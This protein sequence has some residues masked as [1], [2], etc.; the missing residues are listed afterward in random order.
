MEVGRAVLNLKARRGN[1][2]MRKRYLHVLLIMAMLLTVLLSSMTVFGADKYKYKTINTKAKKWV[3]VKQGLQTYS[4][5]SGKWTYT[6]NMYKI[7]VS[8]PG[9][10]TIKWKTKEEY[11]SLR[12]YKQKKD[13]KDGDS[14]A[15]IERNHSAKIAVDKGVYY[16]SAGGSSSQPGKIGKFQYTFKKVKPTANY[17]PGTAKYLTPGKTATICMTPEY[18]YSRWYRITLPKKKSITFWCTKWSGGSKSDDPGYYVTVY[19]S[20][21]KYIDM[22]HAGSGSSQYFSSDYQEAGTY[23]IRVKSPSY[24][25]D[26]LYGFLTTLKWK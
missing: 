3:N 2:K 25:Y 4:E 20:D 12:L 8:S 11:T 5:K 22:E 7:K 16:A 17:S 26:D 6:N 23:Y 21:L 18:A 9:Y 1:Q 19:D 13:Y 14:F 24:S 15:S 10:L